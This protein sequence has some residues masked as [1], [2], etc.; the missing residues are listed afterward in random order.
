MEAANHSKNS[1]MEAENHVKHGAG[2]KSL[3]SRE[4]VIIIA[5]FALLAVFSACNGDDDENGKNDDGFKITASVENGN[6]YNSTI[7]TVKAFSDIDC[8]GTD[9][10]VIASAAYTNGSFTLTLPATPPVRFLWDIADFF[11]QNLEISNRNAKVAH[12][13]APSAYSSNGEWV[14]NFAYSKSDNNSYTYA[15]YMYADMDVTITGSLSGNLE[16]DLSLKKGWN[17]VYSIDESDIEK[18]TT[19]VISGLKWH[20]YAP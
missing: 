5:L 10:R 4:N 2:S 19:Q 8:T 13:D 17:I 14:G 11:S 16:F 18:R 7:S 15:Y 20:F 9:C 1:A 12:I 3:M 6:A